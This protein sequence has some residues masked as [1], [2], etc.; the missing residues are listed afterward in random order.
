MRWNHTQI[1][2]QNT[3]TYVVTGANSGIG[4]ETAR[5]LCFKGA[6]VFLACRSESKARIAMDTIRRERSDVHI[7]FVPLDLASLKSVRAFADEVAKRTPDG[8]D[9]L[10]NNA[11]LMAPP[12][13]LTEDGFEMQL[14]T[15]HL[16]HFALTG[17]LLPQLAKR[18]GARVVNVSSM[19]H[20]VGK[21]HLDD[22]HGER[23][24][25]AWGFYG[26]SKLANLLFTRE[27]NRRLAV[28][29]P[30]VIATAAHPGYSATALQA[31]QAESHGKSFGS[32]FHAGN[33]LM[34]QSAAMGALPTLRAAVDPEA[35]GDDFFGPS[36]GAWG[37]PHRA[38]RSSAAQNDDVARALWQ[39]SENLTNVSYLT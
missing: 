6:R 3:R 10:I 22:L 39:R 1:P 38:S 27:L 25:D 26:Q 34:A 36:M 16:G 9:G 33:V 4:F 2:E 37:Y 17:L 19:M 35:R 14:G 12:R 29:L 20:W 21:I 13:Q 32:V 28:K 11:G 5:T 30:N 24:Y 8:I 15:N 7:D 18:P 31:T 23:S